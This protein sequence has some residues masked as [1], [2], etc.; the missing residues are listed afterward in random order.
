M[1]AAAQILSIILYPMLMP[2]YAMGF[3]CYAMHHYTMPLP[4][5]Y[6]L[7]A[8]LGTLFFMCCVPMA[9]I[10]FLIRK[11]EITDIYL[12]DPRER[13]V[14]YLYSLFACG[15]WCYFLSQILHV[16]AIVLTMAIAASCVL[17]I[18][19]IITHWWKI[20]AHLAFMGTLLAAVVG[21]SWQIGINPLWI[22]IL[23]LGLTLLLMY[24]RLYLKQHNTL[25]VITGFLLG[26]TLTL[27]PALIL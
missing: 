12:R 3:F 10:L 19:M 13:S 2:T 18:V 8:I 15:F 27:I 16:P 22:I 5:S 7:I 23:L 20:S 4:T 11:K 9:A 6:V 24:A 1:K 17:L 25:Q 21:Y 26:F 14:P